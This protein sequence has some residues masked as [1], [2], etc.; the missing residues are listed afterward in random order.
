MADINVERK[1]PSIWPWIIGLLVLALLIWAIAEMVSRDEEV[2]VTP[3]EEPVTAVPA[4]EPVP[5]PEAGT[6]ETYE[7]L[8]PLGAEDVGHR[9]RVRG[10][11]VGQVVAEGFWLQPSGAVDQVIFV[12]LP[13][14][15]ET[16]ER[17]QAE[18]VKPGQEVTIVGTVQPAPSGRAE[19][20]VER[21]QLTKEPGYAGWTVQREFMIGPAE[22][23]TQ[24]GMAP[25]QPTQPGTT[26]G[27]AAPDTQM[28]QP[29]DT[30][31][32]RY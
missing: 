9:V 19:T 28:R 30:V 16:G 13:A 25:T 1:G 21:T 15:T 8:A 14:Q 11:V 7:T 6:A 32:G 4:P 29:G 12:Q 24:P 10:R 20:W 18:G 22:G 5:V 3:V 26:P 27:Q 31:R 23:A 17:L 2:A